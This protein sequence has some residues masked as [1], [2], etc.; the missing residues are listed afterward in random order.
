MYLFNFAFLGNRT[1]CLLAFIFTCC[2]YSIAS[3]D[4]YPATLKNYSYL[5]FENGYPTR[6]QYR[7]AQNDANLTARA[8][9]DLVFQTGY[10]SL[11]LDCDDIK[12]KGYDNLIGSD[13]LTALNEEV[14]EF[15][16]ASSFML[17]V[18]QGGVDYTCSGAV[19]QA[20]GIDNVRLVESGQYVKRVDH[21]GLVFTDAEGNELAVDEACRLEITAWPDRVTFLLDGSRETKNPITRATIQIISPDG[22]SHLA[23][24]VSNQAR[25]TLQPQD[26]SRLSSLNTADYVKLATNLQSDT[27]LSVNFDANTH[28]FSIEVPADPVKYPSAT[29]RVDEYLIEITN[30]LASTANIPL[31]FIQPKVRAVTGTVMILCDA[32]SGRPLGIP[33]QISKNWHGSS[34]YVHAGSW[35]RGSTM[36]TLKA[37][38]SRR[39]KLRVA[40]GYWGGSGTVSHSQ[41]SLIGHGSNWKWDESALGAWGETMTFDPTLHLGAAFLDDIRPTFTKSTNTTTGNIMTAMWLTEHITGRKMSAAV[42]SLFTTTVPTPTTG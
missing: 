18:T 22:V 7:R 5:Y 31:R 19:V 41:L 16:P 34:H 28:A 38:E 33:V 2:L 12:L 29:N 21:L 40:Y 11:M 6:I 1:F 20:A 30:P 4:T 9:P 27:A 32:D 3:G 24:V 13:Y 39:M 15:T 37:G 26:D 14:T 23:D 42:T 10:Y 17:R 35:L 25:L 36:L 8:N